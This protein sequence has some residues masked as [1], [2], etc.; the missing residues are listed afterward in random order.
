M[1]KLSLE[2]I[3][4]C[5]PK[6][7]LPLASAH[8]CGLAD[9]LTFSQCHPAKSLGHQPA[10]CTDTTDEKSL[11]P[12]FFFELSSPVYSADIIRI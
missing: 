9:R 8:L 7:T 1:D 12:F 11:K 4:H 6:T 2:K 3:Y 5:Q 10:S